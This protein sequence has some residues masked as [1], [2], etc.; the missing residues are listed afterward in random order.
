MGSWMVLKNGEPIRVYWKQTAEQ[1]KRM[2]ESF[3]K[4]WSRKD[5][6]NVY[7]IKFG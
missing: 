5:P 7:T 6:D 4:K 1:G 3:V 2:A